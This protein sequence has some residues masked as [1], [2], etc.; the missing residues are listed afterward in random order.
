MMKAALLLLGVFFLGIQATF[1]QDTPPYRVQVDEDSVYV[2]AAPTFTAE[3]VASLFRDEWIEVVS[4]NLDGLW[5]EVRRP[6]RMTNLGWVYNRTLEWDFQP[7]LLPLGDGTTGL[8]GTT[9]V[10]GLPR[11]GVYLL[12]GASMRASP[13]RRAPLLAT[14]P[15]LVTVPVLA[16][17]QTATWLL[18]NYLGYEG[19]IIVFATRDRPDL[20]TV[21]EAPGL[22]PPDEPAVVI[23]PP[24]VQQAQV[25]RLRA[26][27]LERRTLARDLEGF[28]WAVFKGEIMPCNP[29]PSV[30]QYSYSPRDI[31]ELPELQRYLPRLS[32]AVDLVN[33]AIAPLS[34]CGIVNPSTVG[35]ARDD[36]INARIIFDATLDVLEN[37]EE[38]VI[39]NTG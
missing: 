1:A 35:D 27:I 20:M 19:W 3:N 10:A 8:L 22:P 39:P 9:P 37:L 15:P 32:E 28:W 23:I 6:G 5:F 2:R 29:P 18:V 11:I 14:V 33:D 16:R 21:P 17:N 38:F 13:S 7:E 12:E 26:F 34:Q 30:A 25:D 4:R 24:E 31:Q 36:A